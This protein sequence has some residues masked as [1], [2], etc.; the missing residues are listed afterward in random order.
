MRRVASRRR[1]LQALVGAAHR[2]LDELSNCLEW[3][4]DMLNLLE[5]KG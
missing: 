2:E 3:V 1:S 5:D 4:Q